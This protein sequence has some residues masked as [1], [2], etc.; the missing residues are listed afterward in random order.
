MAEDGELVESGSFRVDRKRALDKLMRFQM[1][2]TQFFLLPWIR[3]AVASGASRIG[4]TT[5]EDGIE[6]RFDG[7]AFTRAELEDPYDCLFQRS[8]PETIR[9]RNLA[10]GL[11]TVLRLKPARVEVTSGSGQ[12]RVC[13]KVESLEV[14]SI[15]DLTEFSVETRIQVVGAKYWSPFRREHLASTVKDYCDRCPIPISIEGQEV[16]RAL[17]VEREPG[18]SF[19]EAEVHGWIMVPP[20]DF[21]SMFRAYSWGAYAGSFQSELPLVQVDGHV[22][23]DRFILNVSQ[24]GVVRN[25]RFKK[26]MGLVAAQAERLLL[27]TIRKQAEWLTET[28][29]LILDPDLRSYWTMW[30]ERGLAEVSPSV[31]THIREAIR[32]V[33]P[34]AEE[35]TRQ[36]QASLARIRWDARVTLWLRDACGRLLHDFDKD[37]ANPTFKALWEA[38]TFFSVAGKPLSLRQL[39]EQRL[40]LGHVPVSAQPYSGLNLPYEVVWCTCEKERAGLTKRFPNLIQDVTERL[41]ALAM[42]EEP[43]RRELEDTVMPVARGLYAKLAAEY[44]PSIKTPR[45]VAIRDRLLDYLA[46]AVSKAAPPA[47]VPEPD[48]WIERVPLFP[49]GRGGLLSGQDWWDYQQLRQAFEGDYVFHVV[50]ESKAMQGLD[51]KLILQWGDDAL[52]SR[53]LPG[54]AFLEVPGKPGVTLL[55][56]AL[57]EAAPREEDA[58]LEAAIA[59]VAQGRTSSDA[60]DNPTRC[61]LLQ[62][63]GRY[64]APWPGQWKTERHR[65]LVELLEHLPMFRRPDGAGW[66]LF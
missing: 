47:L 30:I 39:E 28:G 63:I 55:F 57:P 49:M 24:F 23:D 61:A 15:I 8:R 12:D 53:L 5:V 3:C 32:N 26:T 6:M 66:T 25:A 10:I 40:R 54:A 35:S 34:W 31:S 36:R 56:K 44:D 33:I 16:P 19:Q 22:S 60:P 13:L 37:S 38:P 17:Q 43:E 64:F 46:F 7:R 20:F 29:R 4:L 65:L 18:L 59:F 14:E 2:D 27:E 62:A 11:L 1:S 50:K 51:E 42:L 45:N 48:Q 21:G 9:N 41:A 58:E 52:L